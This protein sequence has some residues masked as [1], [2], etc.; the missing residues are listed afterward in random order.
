VPGPFPAHR[1]PATDLG[2]LFAS[3]NASSSRLDSRNTLLLKLHRGLRTHTRA[4]PVTVLASPKARATSFHYVR[5]RSVR[6]SRT[7]PPRSLTAENVVTNGRAMLMPSAVGSYPGVS[8]SGF[9]Q[10]SAA[11]RRVI[12]RVADRSVSGSPTSRPSLATITTVLVVSRRSPKRRTNSASDAPIFVP[13]PQAFA[14]G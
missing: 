6:D 9:S 2:S 11:D 3:W 10:T 1:P 13:P 7:K 4:S 14:N 12:A 8:S 5:T